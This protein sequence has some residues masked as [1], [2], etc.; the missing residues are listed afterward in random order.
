MGGA[1]DKDLLPLFPLAPLLFIWALQL[2]T[3]IPRFIDKESNPKSFTCS[4][5]SNIA[6]YENFGRLYLGLSCEIKSKL[7]CMVRSHPVI[8]MIR[9]SVHKRLSW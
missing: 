5:K 6:V 3:S 8:Y 4:Q 1:A 7:I 9:S 2:R